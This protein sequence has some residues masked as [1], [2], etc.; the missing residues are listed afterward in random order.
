MT[1]AETGPTRVLGRG[2]IKEAQQIVVE[3]ELLSWQYKERTPGGHA[4]AVVVKGGI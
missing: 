3:G 2:A 1:T 4:A